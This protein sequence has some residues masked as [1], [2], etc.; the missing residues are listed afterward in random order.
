MMNDNDVDVVCWRVFPIVWG[1]MC[2]TVDDDDDDVERS[3][4][5][6]HRTT[7]VTPA[8]IVSN[9]N[10]IEPKC[11]LLVWHNS[12][13]NLNLQPKQEVLFQCLPLSE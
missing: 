10:S 1:V 7:D 9:F 13:L 11:F 8:I 2:C 5:H 4:P 6:G 3:R 12:R